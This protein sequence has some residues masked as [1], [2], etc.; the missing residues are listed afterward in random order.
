MGLLPTG[1]R[2]YD[3]FAAPISHGRDGHATKLTCAGVSPVNDLRYEVL[4]GYTKITVGI[5]LPGQA[6]A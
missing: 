1:S 3:F 6:K 2:R 4:T 5:K